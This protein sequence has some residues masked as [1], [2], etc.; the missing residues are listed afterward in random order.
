MARR[1]REEREE[2][3]KEKRRRGGAIQTRARGG[4]I[5]AEREK[6]GKE[7]RMP[8]PKEDERT[9]EMVEEEEKS[10]KFGGKVGGAAPRVHL[11]RRARGGRMTPKSP[12]S[13]ADVKHMSYET[14]LKGV[15]EGGG[16]KGGPR[17]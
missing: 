10:R 7:P 5:E 4:E 14:T 13:G 17:P 11:G 9:K 1:E 8:K 16:G 2:E 15:D 3:R 6:K 12:F